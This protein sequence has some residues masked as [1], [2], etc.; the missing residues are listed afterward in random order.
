MAP[1]RTFDAAYRAG[2]DAAEP[3]TA[4]IATV[5]LP[6]FS[7]VPVPWA[8]RYWM[9]A[10]VRPASARASVIAAMAPVAFGV[11]IGDA[12]RIGGG[13]VADDFGED[14]CVAGLRDSSKSFRG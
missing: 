10:G 11:L 1:S 13:A 14:R 4:L 5:S 6:S 7:L 8:L 2:A 3:K 9:S 12:E